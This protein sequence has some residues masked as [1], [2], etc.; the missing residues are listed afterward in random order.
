MGKILIGMVHLPALPGAPGAELSMDEIERRA[1]NEARTLLDAG[2]NGCILENFGDTPF[3]KDHVAPVTVAAMARVV[4]AVC[5]AFPDWRVGVNVLRND[6]RAAL[7]IASVCGARFVRINVHVGAT[8]TDQ[9]VVEGQAAETLRLRRALGSAVEIWADVQVKHGQSLAHA[10]IAL[11]AEDAV[12][13]GHADTLV[14]SGRATGKATDLAE[15]KRVT[16]LGL[17]VPVLV[18]SGA[19]ERSAPRYLEVADGI[20]VG[21]AL[22]VSPDPTSPLDPERVGRFVAAARAGR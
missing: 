9:G 6:A 1:V 19:D 5:H 15:L 21:T 17:G 7:S 13:R 3:H 12:R 4:A 16:D 22:K 14:V 8:A 20:I 2:F 18:G 11:E 10:D